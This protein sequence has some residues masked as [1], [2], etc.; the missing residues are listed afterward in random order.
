MNIKLQN[1]LYNDYPKIF[2]DATKSMKETCMCWG[3]ECG[4]GWYTILDTLCKALTRTYSTSISLDEEDGKRLGIKPYQWKDGPHYSFTVECPQVVADQVKEKYGTLRFYFHLEY[5]DTITQLLESKKYPDLSKILDRFSNFIDGIVHYAEIAAGMTCEVT[6][7]P[8]A[9]HTT[10]GH[11]YKTLNIEFA[12]NDESYKS[13]EY[14]PVKFK[15]E[16]T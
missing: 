7:K 16:E 8:G 1:K 3:C 14:E 11:W 13:R 5:S 2:K 4:D 6:G 9:L 12:A 15:N 10:P